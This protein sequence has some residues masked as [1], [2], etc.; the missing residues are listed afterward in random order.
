[1]GYNIRM[2]TTPATTYDLLGHETAEAALW[3]AQKSGRLHHGWLICGASGIGKATLA[4][5]FARF[6]L[7]GAK[8][9]RLFVPETNPVAKRIAASA[10]ADLVVVERTLRD[11]GTLRDEI[12]IDDV[13]RIEPL[14]RRTSAEGGWRIV[15]I[16]EADLMN[17]AA[18][19]AV[20]KLLEEPP[21]GALLL[22]TAEASGRLL[23]TI[24]S[25]V[26]KITLDSLSPENL[27]TLITRHLP[28]LLPG[29]REPLVALAEGSLGRAIALHQADGVTVYR[30]LLTLLND[31]QPKPMLLFAEKLGRRGG[32]EGYAMIS[33]LFPDWLA[34][35][36]KLAATG[37][38]IER[39]EGE[40]TAAVRLAQ[41]LGLDRSLALWDKVRGLFVQADALNLDRKQVLLT[42]LFAVK[43]AG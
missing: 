19:N 26:R 2:T 22:L 33:R 1:M 4:F 12:V 5:R 9:D 31:P 25:R 28:D 10:H 15:I 23:P 37:E 32:E 42:A 14:F 36:S 3:D 38:M 11:N 24:R 35:V 34:R 40:G 6:L 16:D 7:A 29:E 18:Q 27:A 30:E 39:I 21:P 17:V 20:L 43:G 13:R 41:T 8:G